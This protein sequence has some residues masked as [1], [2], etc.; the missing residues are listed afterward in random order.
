MNLEE[1]ERDGYIVP[2]QIK[3]VW[4]VQMKL[5]VK[6][7]EVCKKHHL[8]IWASSGTLL[9]AVR[10]KGYIPW[11]DDV[12]MVMMRDD[13]QKLID[14]A[15]RE[16]AS[17]YFFQCAYTE[18][19]PYHRG[20]AQLRMND[21]AAILPHDVNRNF[22]QGI[23]ID[24]FVFDALPDDESL[25]ASYVEE[26][27]E[28]QRHVMSAYTK[29]KLGLN[30]FGNLRM[31]KSWIYAHTHDYLK[32][33]RAYEA[34]LSKYKISENRYVVK[35]GLI[36][37]LQY[38]KDKRIDKSCYVETI[39]LPFEDIE[40]PVPKGYDVVLSTLYG[41]Y[42]SPVKQPTYHGGFLVLDPERSYQPYLNELRKKGKSGR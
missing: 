37:N 1:E 9:G 12:D 25:Y 29:F 6:L 14:V 32:T 23:F 18:S 15:S 30:P 26:L 5:L 31:L 27:D 19:V 40:M 13:Y 20:H 39:Y 7:L 38:I 36:H 34:L 16:F 8:S 22:H 11:D 42:M 28:A 33:F 3:Q 10:H 41:D 35:S 24:I 2:R 17:P 4:S 21:T